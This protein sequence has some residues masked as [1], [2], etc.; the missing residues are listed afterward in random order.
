LHFKHE[1]I[2]FSVGK[3]S[4]LQARFVELFFNSEA[5]SQNTSFRCTIVFFLLNYGIRFVNPLTSG[6]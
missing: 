3:V 1:S 4:N 2:L 6:K 5:V